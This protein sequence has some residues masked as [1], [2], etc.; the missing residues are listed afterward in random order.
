[1]P[2]EVMFCEEVFGIFIIIYQMDFQQQICYSYVA[3]CNFFPK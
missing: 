1:M 3:H 2:H